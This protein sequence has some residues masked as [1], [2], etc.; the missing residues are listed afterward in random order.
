MVVAPISSTSRIVRR[1]AAA[2]VA[3]ATVLV[4]CGRSATP[5]STADET[6]PPTV[7][8]AS[9]V[10]EPT[11][12]PTTPTP[13]Y[14]VQSGDSL[15]VVATRFG[16]STATLAEF[17]GISDVDTLVVGQELRIPPTTATATAAEDS[18]GSSGG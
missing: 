17:N 18:T 13:T 15:S 4:G 2:A 1:R 6:P 9:V 10:A 14:V 8:A 3:I 5:E 16:V 7:A 12:A 11:T